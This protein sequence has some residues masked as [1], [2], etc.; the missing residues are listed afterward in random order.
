MVAVPANVL[1]NVFKVGRVCPWSPPTHPFL[2][3]S[4]S[5]GPLSVCVLNLNP[6]PPLI[7]IQFH[8]WIPANNTSGSQL[9]CSKVFLVSGAADIKHKVGGDPIY[10]GAGGRGRTILHKSMLL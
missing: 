8:H 1:R 6:P 3:V 2:T 10:K 7:P 4:I 9:K 5:T